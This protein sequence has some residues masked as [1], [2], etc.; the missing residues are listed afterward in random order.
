MAGQSL[1]LAVALTLAVAA[2]QPGQRPLPNDPMLAEQWYLFSPVDRTAFFWG[3]L[4]CRQRKQKSSLNPYSHGTRGS[5]PSALS[6]AGK[7]S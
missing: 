1:L 6:L 4:I 7:S 2:S 5:T 3:W